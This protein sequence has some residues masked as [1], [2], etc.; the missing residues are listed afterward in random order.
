MVAD[1]SPSALCQTI[2]LRCGPLGLIFHDQPRCTCI[3][4]TFG[5]GYTVHKHAF[6]PTPVEYDAPPLTPEQ[7]S[8]FD[9]SEPFT[10]AVSKV[11]NEYFPY[12]LLAIVWKYQFYKSTQYSLQ[13]TI[14]TAHIKEM[15]FAEKALEIL[16]EMENA[17]MLGCL[18]T[19]MDILSMALTPKPDTHSAYIKAIRGFDGDITETTLDQRVN[20]HC[21]IIKEQGKPIPDSVFNEQCA[22]EQHILDE[23]K[24]ALKHRKRQCHAHATVFPL[25]MRKQCFRYGHF[26]HICIHCPRCTPPLGCK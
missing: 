26:G 22:K 11:V 8:I 25:H 10:Y 18:L 14:Q 5:Q 7:L 23:H 12:N 17:N 2:P 21:S 3:I 4:G 1:S 15:K 13:R 19:H 16:L 6:Q 24:D 9:A 20:R